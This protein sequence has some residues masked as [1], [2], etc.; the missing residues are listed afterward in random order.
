MIWNSLKIFFKNLVYIFLPMGIIY[1]F[2]LIAG[3]HL[4]T[5]LGRDAAAILTPLASLVPEGAEG[6]SLLD[7]LGYLLEALNFEDG[8][9]NVLQRLLSTEW[10]TETLRGFMTSVGTSEADL[11]AQLQGVVSA[12]RLQALKEVGLAIAFCLIG[13]VLANYITRFVLKRRSVVKRGVGGTVRRLVISRTLVPLLQ[14]LLLVVFFILLLY[15]QYYAVLVTIALLIF[16][17][18][19]S[20]TSS[21]LVYRRSGLK[22]K[23]V[24]TKRNIAKYFAVILIILLLNF[25]VAAVHLL[26]SPLFAILLILPFVVYSFAIADINTDSYVST[27]AE[28]KR[29]E[30]ERAKEIAKQTK[31]E[32]PMSESEPQKS[33]ETE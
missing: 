27:L 18:F 8:L 25:A 23:E 10:L 4:L 17:A 33:E 12:F 21:W 9:L 7:F 15:I 29:A 26:I 31:N 20:L 13:I 28:K 2:L 22:L 11:D 32:A 5:S 16:L 6:A 24:L 30:K 1:L 3:Y 19:F 14:S